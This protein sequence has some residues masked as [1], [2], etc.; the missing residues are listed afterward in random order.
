MVPHRTP[1][2][3]PHKTPHKTAHMMPHKT[4]HMVPHKTTSKRRY[5][6]SALSHAEKPILQRI[7]AIL[8][9]DI[10]QSST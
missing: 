3:T 1:R 6:P 10:F 2:I 5:C 8:M 9:S 7:A 4:A